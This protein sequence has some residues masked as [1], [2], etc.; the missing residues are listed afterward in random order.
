MRATRTIIMGMPICV[1]V[2]DAGVRQQNLDAVFAEFVAVD[3]QFSPFNDDS[4]IS[5]LN[6]GEIA[7][8]PCVM[9]S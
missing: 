4:K 6:R 5:W 8:R 3:A 2:A 7:R 1:A 9:A